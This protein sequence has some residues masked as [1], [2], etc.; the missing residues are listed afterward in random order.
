M[1]ALV[2]LFGA[3]GGFIGWRATS[4]RCRRWTMLEDDS[5]EGFFEGRWRRVPRT[6]RRVVVTF[7]YAAVGAAVGIIVV[8]ELKH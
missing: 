4:R 3:A 7:L 2:L 5:P 1:V 8:A 6:V